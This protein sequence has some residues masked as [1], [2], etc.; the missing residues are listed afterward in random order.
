MQARK[1]SAAPNRPVRR[2]LDRKF[3]HILYHNLTKKA[4]RMQS[5]VSLTAGTRLP[6]LVPDRIRV[7]V[8]QGG[9]LAESSKNSRRVEEACG[10]NQSAA[11]GRGWNHDR[12]ERDP[13]FTAGRNGTGDQEF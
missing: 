13:P 8:F 1:F 5:P 3:L 9:Y 12:R 11:D 2:G 10:A 7:R 6:S 4:I